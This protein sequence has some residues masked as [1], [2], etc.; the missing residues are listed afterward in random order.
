MYFS[1]KYKRT[2]WGEYIGKKAKYFLYK[3]LRHLV[4]A[5]LTSVTCEYAGE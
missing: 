5:N 4:A 1:K 3:A 2:N